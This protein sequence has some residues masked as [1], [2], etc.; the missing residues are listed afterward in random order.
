MG[1]CIRCGPVLQLG[2]RGGSGRLGLV[3]RVDLGSG[4]NTGLDRG[5]AAFPINSCGDTL[6]DQGGGV[7]ASER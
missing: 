6:V 3:D 2:V 4:I 1:Q 7:S 5:L